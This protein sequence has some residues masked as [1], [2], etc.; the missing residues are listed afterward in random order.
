MNDLRFVLRSLAKSP[1]FTA[2]TVLTLALG[3]GSSTAIFSVADRVLFRAPPYPA[4]E[5]LVVLGYK[6]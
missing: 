2:A 6:W 5:Q 4:P 3:I 1:G